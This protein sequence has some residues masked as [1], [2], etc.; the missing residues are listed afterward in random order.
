MRSLK[1]KES[2]P[3]CLQSTELIRS[4]EG[5]NLEQIL[6]KYGGKSPYRPR[7]GHPYHQWYLSVRGGA[8]NKAPTADEFV[9]LIQLIVWVGNSRCLLAHGFNHQYRK[10][11]KPLNAWVYEALF[12]IGSPLEVEASNPQQRYFKSRRRSRERF[13][14][15]S[16][17][18]RGFI[19]IGLIMSTDGHMLTQ[20]HQE[21]P[22]DP[23]RM[24]LNE[25][26]GSMQQSIEGLARQF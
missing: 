9:F 26:L 14:S 25:I 10:E 5:T 8:G 7:Q 22:S 4:N 13:G 20:S 23:S 6:A 16:S 2:I 15:N 17:S 24:N 21:G 12:F 11:P 3:S 19:S 1:A 18:T